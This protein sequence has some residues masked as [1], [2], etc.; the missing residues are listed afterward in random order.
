MEQLA[1]LENNQTQQKVS[2]ILPKKTVFIVEDNTSIR[3]F[4]VGFLED[5]GYWVKSARNGKEAINKLKVAASPSV[6]LVDAMMP[7]MNGYELTHW[8]RADST[9]SKVP[10][11]MMS[12]FNKLDENVEWD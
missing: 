5:N 9:L 12:A 3:E 10:I 4:L 11:V 7:E 2:M 8:L 1:R 6:F